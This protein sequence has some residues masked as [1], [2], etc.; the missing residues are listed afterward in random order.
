[1]SEPEGGDPGVEAYLAA[2]SEPRRTDLEAL[3][4]TI[5]SAAPA[6]EESI[7]YDMPAYRLGGRFLVSFG[8]Y[9]AHTSLFPASDVVARALG[10]E[11]APYLAGRGTI[12]FPLSRPIPLDL[13]RR[14]VEIRV[15][16]LGG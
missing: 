16:E 12:R 1:M 10:D 7:A 15:G 8:A 13:V 2:V 3:R 6:A 11:I 4:A 9:K 5:R 14:V